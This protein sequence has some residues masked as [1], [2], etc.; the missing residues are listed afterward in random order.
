M[1]RIFCVVVVVMIATVVSY[2]GSAVAQ[3]FSKTATPSSGAAAPLT[4]LNNYRM[5]MRLGFRGSLSVSNDRQD[6]YRRPM[7]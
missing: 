7:L 3:T 4:T 1:K 6:L 5:G 2:S